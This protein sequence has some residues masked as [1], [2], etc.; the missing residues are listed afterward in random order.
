MVKTIGNPLSWFFQGVSGASRSVGDATVALSGEAGATPKVR[1]L[2]HR[3]LSDALHKGYADFSR[4]RSDVMFLV[5]IYPAIG[6]CLSFFAFH[7]AM[8]PMLFPLAA[9]FL[10]LG[11]VVA[12]GL[13][14]M[15][16]QAERREEVGWSAALSVVRAENVGPVLVMAVYLLA[17]FLIWML[18]AMKI[19]DW[20]LGPQPP[21][22]LTGFMTDVLTTGPGWTM[23][24]VGIAVGAVFAVTVLAVSLTTFPMLIDR[25]VG[26]AVAVA[27]SLRV[28]QKNPAIV[29]RWGAIVAVLML[30][31]TVPL[32]LGLII[33]LP[34]LGHAT[35]H[36]YRAAVGWV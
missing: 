31:G 24:V 14:E 36:L 19:Y 1:S 11:P 15:S 21:Q 16:R 7:R 13:Y 22:S 33:V 18:A 23:I 10:L 25:R 26:L 27:T 6:L 2:S 28:M 30:I 5:M 35:W 29:A 12:I 9:G 32:F 34:V 17:V 4:F 8:L 20:T 3:D